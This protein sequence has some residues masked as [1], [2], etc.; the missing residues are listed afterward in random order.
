MIKKYFILSLTVFYLIISPI[1]QA[2]RIKDIATISGI[3]NN[4][5]I[6]YGLV[7]GLN[8]TGDKSNQTPFTDQSFKSMLREFGVNIPN[9]KD[10]QLKNVA[11]V[12][13]S[14]E[15]PAFSKIGQR[16]DIN[17]SSIGNSTSL[18][19]GTLLMTALKGADGQVYAVAQ[20][21]V[22]VSGIGAQG[23]DGSS[24]TVNI[25]SSGAIPNGATVEKIVENPYLQGDHITLNL[26]EPDFTTAERMVDVI[27]A[28]AGKAIASAADAGTVEV[29]IL[30]DEF[31]KTDKDNVN[32]N[33]F[34][35][36]AVTFISRLENLTLEPGDAAA[37]IIVNS[38]TGTVVIGQTVTVAA[39]AVTHGN[40][41]VII[42]EQ[43]YVSQPNPLSGG[44]TV[45]APSSD[46]SINQQK[47][48][49]FIFGPGASLNDIVD[50]VN[51][52]GA[53]PGDLVAILEALKAAGALRAELVVI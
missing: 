51:K 32:S 36:R 50:A 4:Q 49:A 2:A 9:N 42:T 3:R 27:N 24:I 11:A 25:P 44:G 39:A 17:V 6:G 23:A 18:R 53:A 20:G 48:K 40:L 38:K 21:S 8:G 7:V 13:V 52:I 14:A 5:L 29:K 12:A 22:V 34:K 28:T 37:K 31:A 41:S 16:I 45:V 26:N 46:I 30:E 1:T 43:P 10:I 15:L 19:G 35:N 47:S 33:Q